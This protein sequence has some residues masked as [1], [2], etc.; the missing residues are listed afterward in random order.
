MRPCAIVCAWCLTGVAAPSLGDDGHQAAGVGGH[1]RVIH[2]LA[3]VCSFALVCQTATG[4][5]HGSRPN[6]GT[7]WSLRRCRGT[8]TLGSIS[9]LAALSAAR[10]L[11]LR[12]TWPC[13]S[14]IWGWTTDVRPRCA[15]W[16]KLRASCSCSA[17]PTRDGHRGPLRLRGGR[18]PKPL[19]TPHQNGRSRR[20][21]Q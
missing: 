5:T 1:A 15:A 6:P 9:T 17:C 11:W 3:P 2:S 10:P 19:S 14:A 16:R 8:C 21:R 7:C 12:R 18:P 20:M 13:R 4:G